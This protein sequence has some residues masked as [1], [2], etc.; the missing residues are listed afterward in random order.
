MFIQTVAQ[1]V[2]RRGRKFGISWM[3]SNSSHEKNAGKGALLLVIA[4]VAMML[5]FGLK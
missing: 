1:S 3:K 2:I 5:L 4:V